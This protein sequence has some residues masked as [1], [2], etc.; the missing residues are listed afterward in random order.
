MI[1]TIFLTFFYLIFNGLIALL[2]ASAG[3][4]SGFSTAFSWIFGFLW[5]FDYLVPVSTILTLLGL[6][7]TFEAA[8]LVWKIIHWLIAKIP[9][10]HIR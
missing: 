5:N 9:F 2:P 4:P 1:F 8:V 7:F 10:L 3:L 6:A